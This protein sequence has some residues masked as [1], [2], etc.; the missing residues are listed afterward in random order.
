MGLGFGFEVFNALAKQLNAAWIVD[1]CDFADAY[2]RRWMGDGSFQC[3]FDD[4]QFSR[5]QGERLNILLG[6]SRSPARH[7]HE[8]RARFKAGDCAGSAGVLSR[9][10]RRGPN[11]TLEAEIR[12]ATRARRLAEFM[13]GY[14]LRESI[15]AG[16]AIGVVAVVLDM[17][18]NPIGF[19]RVP[20][21]EGSRVDQMEIWR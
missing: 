16:L 11:P 14:F 15:H 1:P 17:S 19:D 18:I 12:M 20:V 13:I 4:F 10:A 8:N 2:I 9:G 7:L 21:R 3:G 6:V 5:S